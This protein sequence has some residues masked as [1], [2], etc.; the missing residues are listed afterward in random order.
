MSYAGEA[1]K[2]GRKPF[3][4][5]ELVLDYCSLVFGV[6]ACPATGSGD[7]KCYNTRTTCQAAALTAYDNQH[8]NTRSYAFYS[9]VNGEFAGYNGPVIMAPALERVDFTPGKL[10]NGH[11]FGT[12]GAVTVTLR[13]FQHHD[14]EI[15]PYLSGR[16]YDPATQGTFFGRLLARN[17]FYQGRPL[18]VLT[19]FI[20]TSAGVGNFKT[21][22]YVIET[23]DGPDAEGLV[24]ITAKD[25][26][27]LAD[28]DRAK[29]P[30]V[31]QGRLA[32]DLTA[33]QTGSVTGMF[34]VK[35][36]IAKYPTGAATI[37]VN[38]EIM[39]YTSLNA[40]S[41]TVGGLTR[42]LYGTTA[43]EHEEADAIQL[44]QTFAA[45]KLVDVVN[46]IM[47]YTEIPSAQL[48]YA[49]WDTEKWLD[50]IIITAVLHEPLGVKQLI[51]ELC[52]QFMFDMWWDDENQVIKLR[53]MAP[54]LPSATV[55]TLTDNGHLIKGRI[56][57]SSQPNDRL[58][59]VW[60]YYDQK[61]ATEEGGAE[62]YR[63][64]Y[65]YANDDAAEAP[66]FG[67]G[68][69]KSFKSRW[70]DG[71]NEGHALTLA[72]RMGQRFAAPPLRVTFSLDAKNQDIRVGDHVYMDS[73]VIQGF[74][75]ANAVTLFQ[76]VSAKEGE[77]GTRYD[78]EAVNL[79]FRGRYAYIAPDAQAI[80]TSASAGEKAAYGFIGPQTGN[81][82]SDGG[83]VYKVI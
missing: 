60:V 82:P 83:E 45:V 13:D 63:K 40:S 17:A 24:K 4:V 28:D 80:Y 22:E 67:S 74:T 50:S 70:L 21:R 48:D 72:T 42:G 33:V 35:W 30:I 8:P 75:G 18:R 11:G 32:I 20:G 79:N 27:K 46:T 59:Q 54:P 81:F 36:D 64:I 53:A 58:T 3:T 73:R 71:T 52:E 5:V 10:S 2:V 6:G 26:L 69:A 39:S 41:G 66:Q 49:N 51:T 16:T 14:R 62:A 47:G 1:V 29:C 65:V 37:R 38:D 7:A 19:G 56:K 43:A 44:C 25:P 15:D 68:R 9:P 77:A 34:D 57:V 76:I 31:T 12:R 23:I 55:Q 61:S 78:Y